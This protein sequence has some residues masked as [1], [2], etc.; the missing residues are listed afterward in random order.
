MRKTIAPRLHLPQAL[1]RNCSLRLG[2][3]LNRRS[4]RR[5]KA[6]EEKK[7]TFLIWSP[8]SDAHSYLESS[9][10]RSFFV[11]ML[12]RHV[13]SSPTQLKILK[14]NLSLSE[15]VWNNKK[16][17]LPNLSSLFNFLD[18]PASDFCWAMAGRTDAF[19]RVSSMS[20]TWC[21]PISLLSSARRR[22]SSSY[23]L[24]HYL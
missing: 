11:Q 18:P 23:H 9:L 3:T 2:R 16:L 14:N 7:N 19:V 8:C 15:W 5:R 13:L 12:V 4:K 22:D 10:G 17:S 21:Y 24:Q 20:T 6:K 1:E